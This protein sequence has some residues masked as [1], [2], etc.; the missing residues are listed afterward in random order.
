M[1]WEN[2]MWN[3]H[4]K[5]L[6]LLVCNILEQQVQVSHFSFTVFRQPACYAASY[7]SCCLPCK[8]SRSAAE[9][10]LLVA[11]HSPWHV[12]QI[13]TP[14]LSY[15]K[16]VSQLSSLWSAVFSCSSA[17]C[18][19]LEQSS[20]HSSL[21]WLCWPCSSL[22]SSP[23]LSDSPGSCCSCCCCCSQYNHP[24]EMEGWCL[25]EITNIQLWDAGTLGKACVASTLLVVYC[26]YCGTL[27][28]KAVRVQPHHN[29]LLSNYWFYYLHILALSSV[30]QSGVVLHK[31][32][33]CHFLKIR[34]GR[35]AN[36]V[37]Q[38]WPSL[39]SSSR[40]SICLDQSK[41]SITK[42]R[43]AMYIRSIS[44]RWQVYCAE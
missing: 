31:M 33:Q 44:R 16:V 20:I 37:I 6:P 2:A 28:R 36:L 12:W 9:V 35:P 10:G 38:S 14:L 34:S 29:H 11:E 18:C 21:A 25:T 40:S 27:V 26:S 17:D 13:V 22:I 23:S 4:W 32:E 43:E 39:L 15:S 5:L 3:L 24:P 8:R 41:L 30:A 42:S 1:C 19:S 7:A